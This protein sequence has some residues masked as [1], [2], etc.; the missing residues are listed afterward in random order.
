MIQNLTAE[1][2]RALIA[3]NPKVSKNIFNRDYPIHFSS[4][5]G[6]KQTKYISTPSGYAFLIT[7]VSVLLGSAADQVTA[8]AYLKST[9]TIKDDSFG[10][11]FQTNPMTL[12][13]V[14]GPAPIV[15]N[16][17]GKKYGIFCEPRN[18][19]YLIEQNQTLSVD[20]EIFKNTINEQSLDI[21]FSGFQI[22]GNL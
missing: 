6:I 21:L 8:D 20:C 4:L 22:R 1:K 14:G 9:I 18:F 7:G 3:R 17:L 13:N 10:V 11:L 12:A 19:S 15:A 5:Q 2:I 16:G